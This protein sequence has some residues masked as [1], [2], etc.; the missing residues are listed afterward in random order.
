MPLQNQSI[1][2]GSLNWLLTSVMTERISSNFENISSWFALRPIMPE[3]C[4]AD[5]IS[6]AYISLNVWNTF[7]YLYLLEHR[8]EATAKAANFGQSFLQD[9]W[10]G[11]EAQ[12]VT[13]RSS[14]KDNDGILHG[15]DLPIR[16][17]MHVESSQY[18]PQSSYSKN[19]M[20]SL[21]DFRETHC[22]IY[23]WNSVC[24]VLYHASHCVALISLRPMH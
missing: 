8:A 21:H 19:T 24:Q 18:P 15:F 12:S 10:E 20:H 23:T 3:T 7:A 16:L 17:K 5:N 6:W 4:L 11:K 22:F 2:T 1:L 14:V 9:S 13:S